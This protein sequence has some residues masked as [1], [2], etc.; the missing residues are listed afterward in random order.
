MAPH[1]KIKTDIHSVN[2]QLQRIKLVPST[3]TVGGDRK[4]LQSISRVR[5]MCLHANR[6][7]VKRSVTLLSPFTGYSCLTKQKGRS[8]DT[9]AS[10][11]SSL[12]FLIHVGASIEQVNHLRIFLKCRFWMAHLGL[13]RYSPF[14][15][16]FE[17]RSYYVD[18]AGLKFWMI[19]NDPP[20]SAP[21]YLGV[22][23]STESRIASAF[24]VVVVMMM[25]MFCWL[26]QGGSHT[27]AYSYNSPT[28]RHKPA[29][30][31][32]VSTIKSCFVLSRGP[33]N[34]RYSSGCWGRQWRTLS[35]SPVLKKHQD[36]FSLCLDLATTLQQLCTSIS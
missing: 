10:E 24:V 29:S 31:E 5:Q 35:P 20:V 26:R 25:T 22:Q 16:V 27:V 33:W 1:A 15:Y 19:S 13:A 28:P 12:F 2:P 8:Q 30:P 14:I 21:K 17:A 11:P 32:T 23:C 6:L 7:D 18:L 9:E 3:L 36:T 4:H 34:T